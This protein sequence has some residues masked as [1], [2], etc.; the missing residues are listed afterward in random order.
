MKSLFENNVKAYPCLAPVLKEWPITDKPV[1]HGPWA[2][3]ETPIHFAARHGLMTK[4]GV[5]YELY[6][7]CDPETGSTIPYCPALNDKMNSFKRI[8]ALKVF[9]EQL[10]PRF[11]GNHETLNHH[12]KALA[13]ALVCHRLLDKDLSMKIFNELSLNWDP[14]KNKTRSELSV[15]VHAKLLEN[16]CFDLPELRKHVSYMKVWFMAL[17]NDARTKGV[18]PSSLFIWL[19]PLD[20]PLFYALNQVGGRTAWSEAAG[21]FSHFIAENRAGRT[22]IEPRVETAAKSLEK[23][24]IR[25]GWLP[26]LKRERKKA[27][28]G[29]KRQRHFFSPDPPKPPAPGDSP[30]AREEKQSPKTRARDAA[31]AF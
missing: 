29:R 10:G 11:D 6:E 18:I 4:N 2:L 25:E 5:E 1:G 7:L 19:K 23:S 20:R 27:P 31:N 8:E 26:G 16:R 28:R 24:L 9:A 3:A 13:S 12:Q 17:L 30:E 21:P 22:L 14:K 15:K